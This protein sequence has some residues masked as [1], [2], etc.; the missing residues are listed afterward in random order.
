MLEQQNYDLLIKNNQAIIIKIAN[1]FASKNKLA[2]LDYDD[3]YQEACIATLQAHTSYNSKKGIWNNYLGTVI[4]NHLIKILLENNTDLSAPS[5]AVKLSQK[6]QRLEKEGKNSDEIRQDLNI[7]KKRYYE[8]RSLV[9]SF[10]LLD[11]KFEKRDYSQVKDI[12][13]ILD[14]ESKKIFLY[15]INGECITFIS[16]QM[17]W[18]VSYTRNKLIKVLQK[19]RQQYGQ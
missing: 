4:K 11:I 13:T 16:K 6:I 15:H 9:H 10:Q 1:Y 8:C 2:S 18:K 3:L 12:L 14:D 7:S 19:I 5:T 17:G